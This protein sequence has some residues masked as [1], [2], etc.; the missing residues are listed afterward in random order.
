MGNS[1]S[2][3]LKVYDTKNPYNCHDCGL[4]CISISSLKE[5]HSVAHPVP[6]PDE[7]TEMLCHDCGVVC[8]GMT[9]LK[10]HCGVAHPVIEAK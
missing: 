4:E 10:V 1:S 2:S 6:E 9:S 7:T 3:T 8:I 5:H